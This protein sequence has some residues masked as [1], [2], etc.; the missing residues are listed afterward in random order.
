MPHL[1]QGI[2]DPQPKTDLRYEPLFP[3]GP[4]GGEDL[5]TGCLIPCSLFFMG[6]RLPRVTVTILISEQH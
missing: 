2:P 1:R 6:L 3:Q 5:E 4:E